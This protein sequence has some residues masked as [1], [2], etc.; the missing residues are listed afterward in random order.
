[1]KRESPTTMKQGARRCLIKHLQWII[2][3]RRREN[4]DG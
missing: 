3:E 2:E 4:D 1:M